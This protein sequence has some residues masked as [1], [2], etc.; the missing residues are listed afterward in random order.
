MIKQLDP[1]KII[2]GPIST[3]RAVREMEANNTL[4]FKVA[5]KATK[6]KIK[7]AIEK[8]FEVKVVDVRTQITPKGTKK[9]FIKL[10]PDA[11]AVDVTSKLG[12]V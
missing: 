12:L 5:K 4:I 11:S 10:A 7:W 2:E 1:S 8:E 6:H 9:A 3:E